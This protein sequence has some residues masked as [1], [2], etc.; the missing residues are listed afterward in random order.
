ME[1]PYAWL[2]A[3]R[4]TIGMSRNHL[5]WII[6]VSPQLV[7]K[8]E[9]GYHGGTDPE[10]LDTFENLRLD[11][12]SAT[13]WLEDEGLSWDQILTFRASAAKLG[14]STGTLQS[15]CSRKGIDPIDFGLLGRWLTHDD[16]AQCRK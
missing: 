14:I 1:Q 15:L 7:Q 10:I 13:A 3:M 12:D 5:C 2:G 8:W 16:L 11:L 9:E 4:K 6:G